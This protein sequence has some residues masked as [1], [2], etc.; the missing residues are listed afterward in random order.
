MLENYIHKTL[1]FRKIMKSYTQNAYL[2]TKLVVNTS[3]EG[4][5]IEQKIERIVSN[6]EPIKDGAPILYIERKE[7][8]RPSTNIR[9]D[10]FE[11]AIEA[12]DK[13]AKSYKAR[14]EERAKD[15]KD[16]TDGEAKSIQGTSEPKI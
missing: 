7:G 3:V 2:P 5:T 13:I 1:K 12:Q 10:R 15:K 4:E 16:G 11:I 14:R 6:K 9:T 8:V